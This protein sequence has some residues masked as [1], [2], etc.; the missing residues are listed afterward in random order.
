MKIVKRVLLILSIFLFGYGTTIVSS[1]QRGSKK[2]TLKVSSITREATSASNIKN[3]EEL[4]TVLRVIDGDTIEL[5]DGRRVRYIG[6][7]TPETVDPKRHVE[8]FGRE[9]SDE[10]KKLV[11]G[12]VVRLQKD[13]SQVDRY[14]RLLRYV[15]VGDTFINDVLV[16]KGYA[17]ADTFPPDV[18]YASQFVEA[19]KEARKNNR[20]LWAGCP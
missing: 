4:S 1:P 18:Q 16:R 13:V 19:Q 12:Q 14:G 20:G 15:Y 6:I 10:N 3:A 9:A 5:T 2:T 7:N 17:Y 11:G 8:C